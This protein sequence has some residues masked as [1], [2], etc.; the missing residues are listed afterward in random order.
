ME[1][2]RPPSDKKGCGARFAPLSGSRLG[3]RK[4]GHLRTALL[5][6]GPASPS[7]EAQLA[8]PFPQL[9]VLCEVLHDP[10]TPLGVLEESN[11]DVGVSLV[12]DVRAVPR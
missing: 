2:P 5:P 10:G 9:S 3:N 4:S 8:G 1:G 11:S 12:E 7:L 6:E